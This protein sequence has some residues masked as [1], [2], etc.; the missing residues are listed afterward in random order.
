MPKQSTDH[1]INLVKR[2]TPAEKRHF[3][4]FV[5]RNNP[6]E[7]PIFLKLFDYIDRKKTYNEDL[8]IREIKG[9]KKTQLANVKANLLKQLLSSL[10]LQMRNSL[11]DINIREQVDFAQ[12]LYAKGL[13]KGAL[14]QL[15]KA[16]KAAAEKEKYSLLQ[17]II[18]FEKHIESLYITGSMYPKAKSLTKESNENINKISIE[19]KLTDFSLS[20]YGL[21][22]QYGYVKNEED[23]NFVTNYFKSK[24]PKV[25]ESKLGFMGK[26]S[27]YQSYVWYYNMVQNFAYY[28]KYAQKWLDHFL[29][30]PYWIAEE[31]SLFIKGYHNL[32]N[33]LFMC[34]RSEK[35]EKRLMELKNLEEDYNLNFLENQRSSFRLFEINHDINNVY[36]SGNYESAQEMA[37]NISQIIIK[38]PYEWDDF[39]IMM[40]DYK[41]ACIYFGAADL[42][43]CILHLNRITN[44]VRP[45]LR[46]DIQCFARILNIIAHF[47][48]GN[49]D[50]VSHQIRSTYRFISKMDNVQKVHREIFAFL[51]RTPSMTEGILHQEFSKLKTKLVELKKDPY[52]R[53]PFLYLDIISWL[54]SKIEGVTMAEAVRKNAFFNGKIEKG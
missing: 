21:Y 42:D 36:L 16:K 43:N 13:Y 34:S 35:F 37:I 8:I 53:R 46:G 12:V 20:L 32:L 39:R 30:H 1:L 27:L 45:H 17:T 11:S 33:G 28:Y 4:I 50:L 10:K 23:F 40:F 22:L 6:K 25:D 52:E 2:M 14:G 24:F 38:N 26:L 44:V 3:K 9:I 18:E 19:N 54:D 51:R 48:L 29:E 47:D 31:T 7:D 41:V 15:E 5:K 49:E